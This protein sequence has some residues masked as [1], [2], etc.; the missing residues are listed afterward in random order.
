MARNQS[1]CKLIEIVKG[2]L[3]R[4]INGSARFPASETIAAYTGFDKNAL[5]SDLLKYGILNLLETSFSY[6]QVSWVK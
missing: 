2:E 4:W 5:E 6:L 1:S 3:G